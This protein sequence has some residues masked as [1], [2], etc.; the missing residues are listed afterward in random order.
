[1]K[2]QKK[3]QLYFSK[4]NSQGKNQVILLMITDGEKGHY[5]A[6]K[7]ISKLLHGVKSKH[8]DSF[9]CANYLHSF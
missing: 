6:L 2:E 9:H 4:Q 7:S 1:M 8:N 3:T 5:L